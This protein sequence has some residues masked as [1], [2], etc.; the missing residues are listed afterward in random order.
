MNF[1]SL[2]TGTMCLFACPLFAQ[3]QPNMKF[4]NITPEDFKPTLYSLD[5]N[6]NAIV[7]ADI[8]ST[9]IIGTKMTEL[10]L[11]FKRHKRIRIMN[12]NGYD[13]AN[14]QIGL[15][16]SGSATEEVKGLKAV[17]YNIENGKVVQTKLDQDNSI[18][19]DNITKHLVVK[20]FTFPNIKEGSII[21]FEYTLKSD[22]IF[23]VQPWDFQGFY[24]CLW[25]EYEVSL[26]EFYYYMIFSQ[27]YQ[28]YAIDTKEDKSGYYSIPG[29]NGFQVS[30]DD[31]FSANIKYHHW[32]VKNAPALK[33]EIYTSTIM[34][35]LSRVE[36][37]LAELRYPFV[38]KDVI[39]NWEEVCQRMLK[40]EEFGLQLKKNNGWLGDEMQEAIKDA[41]TNIDKAKN[42]YAYLRDRMTCS[43]YNSLYAG[44]PLKQVL[45]NKSGSES[46]INLILTA[47]MNKAGLKADPI[48]LS[49]RSHGYAVGL[50]P[51]MN[52]FNYVICRVEIDG[53]YYYLDASHRRL[54]F[55]RLET[56]AYNG[57]AQVIDEAASTLDL[58]ADSLHETKLSSVVIINDDK[59][60]LTGTMKQA[61]GYYESYDLRD[62]I[63]DNG[64]Q[65][66]FDDI[67]K[68]FTMDMEIKDPLIDSLEKYE[69]PL[70]IQY[71]FD[72]KSNGED[73]L[74]VSPMFSEGLKENPFKSSVRTFP[75]EMPY[76]KDET[77]LLRMDVP[78]GYIT[79]ELPKP[80]MLALNDN[81]DGFFEYVISESDG[82]IMMRSRIC[83]KRAI[84]APEEYNTLREFYNMIVKKHNEQIVFKKKK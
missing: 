75:V 9:E 63:K 82:V 10:S 46:E 80:I 25:S 48:M 58:S 2:L 23:N 12:K 57:F 67:K 28:P 73:I 84:Y 22:F 70:A 8:G 42:I 40:D 43:N 31:K 83:L 24:P 45:N 33:S 32:A 47:M 36:F 39:G 52:K 11:E 77:Y 6:A 18:F 37:Q 14:V 29:G 35:H 54:G 71:D 17:T 5:S 56:E 34:N 1:R 21:E 69:D 7:L 81:N 78:T 30:A 53:Q 49:T 50:Y 65:R 15:Y 44:K 74:Y 66:L 38:N 72:I 55:G 3:Q 13:A 41:K 64:K 61:P 26:P 20:K 27:G 19:K 68:D 76:T 60:N 79:D 51:L 4:G 59:G 16:T 62:F